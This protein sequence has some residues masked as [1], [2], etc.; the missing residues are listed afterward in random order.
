[1]AEQLIDMSETFTP[2]GLAKLKRGQV[3]VFNYEGTRVE[4]KIVRLNKKSH[5]LL[6]KRVDLLTIDQFNEVLA[7]RGKK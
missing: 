4:Y 5:K 7:K 2:E 1:M 6:A 3:L